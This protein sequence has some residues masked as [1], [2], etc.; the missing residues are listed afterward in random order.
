[1]WVQ[2]GMANRSLG[3]HNMFSF[4]QRVSATPGL[5]LPGQMLHGGDSFRL[6]FDL[7]QLLEHGRVDQ[8]VRVGDGRFMD[9][10]VRLEHSGGSFTVSVTPEYRDPAV[11][12]Q[13][14]VSIYVQNWSRRERFSHLLTLYREPWLWHMCRSHRLFGERDLHERYPVRDDTLT[15][16]VE[17]EWKEMI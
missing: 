9:M 10:L 15:L 6:D 14:R 12:P 2:R 13:L 17:M 8:R 1:M 7:S 16:G 4:A 3:V 11:Q 5:R